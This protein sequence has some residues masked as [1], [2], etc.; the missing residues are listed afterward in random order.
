MKFTD[1]YYRQDA[2]LTGIKDKE[3]DGKESISSEDYIAQ[4]EVE[5]VTYCFDA[6]QVPPPAWKLD[7]YEQK[8]RKLFFP[9][10]RS[11][12]VTAEDKKV[13]DALTKLVNE[14]IDE[15]QPET[16]YM[17]GSINEDSYTN[18]IE[19]LKKS[20]KKYNVI[21]E[22]EDVKDD[23]LSNGVIKEGNP[24][25]NVIWTTKSVDEGFELNIG[26]M[27]DGT[28]LPEFEKTYEEIED[29]KLN[30]DYTTYKKNDKLDKE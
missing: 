27:D 19:A 23:R 4:V 8:S 1:H 6:Q 12:L 16:F 17:V 18:I 2:N 13:A 22:R 25:G 15:K 5:G 30:K 3:T 21:D 26:E 9:G 14:W 11:G 28:K 7:F 20:I 29:V 24:V 10:G